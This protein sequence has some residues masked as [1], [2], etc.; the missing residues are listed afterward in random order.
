MVPEF[1]KSATEQQKSFMKSFL[2]YLD[3]LFN[4]DQDGI[5]ILFEGEDKTDIWRY[6]KLRDLYPKS[7]DKRDSI[8][9]D[10]LQKMI[11]LTHMRTD[12]DSLC[13]I[14]CADGSLTVKTADLL[15]IPL[16]NTYGVDIRDFGAKP[17][18]FLQADF[19][20]QKI[21][22][23]DCSV[24]LVTVTQ[25]LHHV[26]QYPRLIREISRILRPHGVLIIRESFLLDQTNQLMLDIQHGVYAACVN[27]EM[28]A[29]EFVC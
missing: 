24:D 12:F 8:R 14:G 18:H 5:K 16:E 7:F 27:D 4:F 6:N 3:I 13:D 29:E 2:I 1:S 19:E 26:H 22:L 15:D 17:F 20:V 21:P 28:T 9:T 25:V 23:P 10:Q 11:S